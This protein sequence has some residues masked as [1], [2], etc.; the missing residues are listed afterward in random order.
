MTYPYKWD[1]KGLIEH[2]SQQQTYA[3]DAATK[4]ELAVTI[5]ML[6]E[7]RPVGADGRHGELHTDTCGCDDWYKHRHDPKAVC[8]AF[9]WIGQ[10][11]CHC[12]NCGH[13][14][15][16]H[17][18]HR[19]LAPQKGPFT[20][21]CWAYTPRTAASREIS[22]LRWK[23]TMQAGGYCGAHDPS[24]YDDITEADILARLDELGYRR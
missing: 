18:E 12:D 15:W 20:L 1:P 16:E 14:G 24:E 21:D 17:A 10:A 9:Q 23:L 4:D 8:R 5:A 19:E 11:V 13:P 7:H 22:H 2:L 3:P 6:R